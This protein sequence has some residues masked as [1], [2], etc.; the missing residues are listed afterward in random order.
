MLKG[1]DKE[2]GRDLAEHLKICCWL[3]GAQAEAYAT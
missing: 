1:E 2:L 3:V